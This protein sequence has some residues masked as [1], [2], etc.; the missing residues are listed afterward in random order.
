MKSMQARLKELEALERRQE[1]IA[2]PLYII[3][4]GDEWD[5]IERGDPDARVLPPG[6]KVY[7][8]IS[9]DEWGI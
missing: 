4:T 9:P 5:A 8:D 3:L 6:I 1:Q 7:I 2:H